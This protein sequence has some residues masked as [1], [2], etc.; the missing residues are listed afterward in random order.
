MA[1]SSPAAGDR[2]GRWTLIKQLGRGGNGEVWLASD[3]SGTQVAIKILLKLKP[4]AYTR[5]RDEIHVMQGNADISGILSILDSHL[6]DDLTEE[7]PW[8]AMPPAT[9]LMDRLQGKS[10]MDKVTAIAAIA[11][12]IA[13][14]HQRG[15]IHRDIKPGNLLELNGLY[16]VGDFGLAD[17]PD[18]AD[19]TGAHEDLGPKWT[20][21]PEVRRW[22]PKSDKRAADVYSLA[23]TL[24]ILIT[25]NVLGFD[26]QYSDFGKIGLKNFSKSLYISPLNEL[27]KNSTDHDPERRPA[28]SAFASN[29]RQWL[30]LATS[31]PKW[32]RLE[33]AEVQN[34]IFPVALPMRC[35]WESADDIVRI[36]ALL[37]ERSNLNHL[38]FPD[39]GGL[40]LDHASRSS[41]ES[42]CIEL[43]MYGLVYIV[44]PARLIF[45]SFP[46][47]PHWSYFRL[48]TAELKPS[49]VYPDLGADVASEELTD[50]GG[51]KYADHS[52]WDAGE[53]AGE[54]L[55][56]GS[57]TVLR[58]FRGAFVIFQKTSIYNNTPNTYDG[59]HDTMGTDEFR[60]HIQDTISHIAKKAPKG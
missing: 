25:G 56:P 20:M 40:D 24:W 35:A 58:Y 41:R 57:R 47:E 8:F 28:M 14:L 45:E 30:A 36:L 5:F 34:V 2:L 46:N 23:K 3:P 31:F 26:G 42:G 21:A 53:Y 1:Q 43:T 52:C 6:P 10:V 33:W 12:T 15:I 39:G 37:G 9:P 29:L 54:P 4:I 19:V 38:F 22:D 7:R 48:E 18:K 44:N 50:I 13:T 16:V 11:E 49:G 55:P 60:K 27:L 17:Y 59:R 51:A 32:N